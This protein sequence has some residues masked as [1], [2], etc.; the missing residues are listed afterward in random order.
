MNFCVFA[1]VGVSENLREKN[2]LQGAKA[3]NISLTLVRPIKIGTVPHCCPQKE[4][5]DLWRTNVFLWKKALAQKCDKT[6]ILESDATIIPGLK[7]KILG[8]PKRDVVWLDQRTPKQQPNH[9]INECCTVAMLYDWNAL[10]K[11]IFGFSTENPN[12]FA[13]NYN[14]LLPYM[15]SQCNFDWFLASLV[16][17]TNISSLV[18]PVIK[19]PW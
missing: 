13:N 9:N 3:E 18:I 10:S 7:N 5:S 2:L 1:I 4:H 15:R 17:Q 12:S 6:L 16:K 14:P 8:I 11:L 19:H